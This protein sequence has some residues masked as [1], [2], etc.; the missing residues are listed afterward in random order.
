MS[1]KMKEKNSFDEKSI[2]FF[3]GVFFERKE[4]RF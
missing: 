4:R 1:D 2:L 3:G